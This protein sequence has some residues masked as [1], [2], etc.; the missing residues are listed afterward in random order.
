MRDGENLYMRGEDEE[1]FENTINFCKKLHELG[2]NGITPLIAT[3]YPGTEMYHF[4]E[5]F[6]LLA[7]PDEK[8]VLTTVSYAAV[9]PDFVQ[10]NTTWCSRAQAFE[11]WETMR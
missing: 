8:D 6:G 3:P 5:K 4:C 11:R 9:R 1:S 2:V 10:I 7:F